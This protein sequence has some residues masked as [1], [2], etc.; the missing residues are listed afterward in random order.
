MQAL[1]ATK[2]VGNRPKRRRKSRVELFPFGRIIS[3]QLVYFGQSTFK[4][5]KPIASD[6]SRDGGRPRD[7]NFDRGRK[8]CACCCRACSRP[9][10]D[11]RDQRI[12]KPVNGCADVPQY[13]FPCDPH[14]RRERSDQSHDGREAFLVPPQGIA[15]AHAG[16]HRSV[17]RPLS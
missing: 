4:S 7:N 11:L 1:F 9:R 2:T 15:S 10:W 6:A 3:D 14:P 17:V 16:H 8:D 5:G 12:A 13:I